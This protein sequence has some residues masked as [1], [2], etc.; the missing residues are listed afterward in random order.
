MVLLCK[1]S[2]IFGIMFFMLKTSMRKLTQ[3]KV[4]KET[5]LRKSSP[6]QHVIILYT[7]LS[8]CFIMLRKHE[9]HTEHK[10]VF[11]FGIKLIS[12]QGVKI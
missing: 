9:A 2:S 8:F 12:K 3:V 11:I 7:I 5:K 10:S 1:M 6:F 4:K